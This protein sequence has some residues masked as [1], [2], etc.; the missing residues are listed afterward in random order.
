MRWIICF[1]LVL[2]GLQADLAGVKQWDHTFINEG[3][4]GQ[5][6]IFEIMKGSMSAVKCV[7]GH[8]V[9][10]KSDRIVPSDEG[11]MLVS[12][13][14]SR[15]LLPRLYSDEYGCYLKSFMMCISCGYYLPDDVIYCPQCRSD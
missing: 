6:I 5:G 13:D 14:A 4:L 8:K 2:S 1:I 3:L 7:E 11:L 9:Y 12:D 15:L 10:L